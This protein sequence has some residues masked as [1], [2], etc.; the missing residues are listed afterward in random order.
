MIKLRN[1]LKKKFFNIGQWILVMRKGFEHVRSV[2]SGALGVR[3][4]FNGS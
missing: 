1:N 4:Q 3:E 2:V